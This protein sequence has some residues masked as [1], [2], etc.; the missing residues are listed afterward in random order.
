MFIPQ[1]FLGVDIKEK[2]MAGTD[3]LKKVR[4][5]TFIA[6]A[7]SKSLPG[8]SCNWVRDHW[9]CGIQIVRV[10]SE[11]SDQNVYSDRMLAF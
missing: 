7:V 2:S 10:W 9:S 6:C 8:K 5:S 1:I 4:V 3:S 11:R